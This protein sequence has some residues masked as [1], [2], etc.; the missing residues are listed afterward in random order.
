MKPT[1]PTSVLCA[2]LS[3]AKKPEDIFGTIFA[4]ELRDRLLAVKHQFNSF[5]V[6]IHPD[7]NPG[8]KDAGQHV[9]RLLA[10][11]T[12]AEK[13]LKEGS[14]GMPRKAVI[15]ATLRSPA[16]TY[17]VIE[18]YREGEVA[19]LFLSEHDGKRCLLKVVRQPTDNDL[20]DVEAKVLGER[21]R[22]DGGASA[23]TVRGRGA[24]ERSHSV[25]KNGKDFGFG[26]IRGA[27]LDELVEHAVHSGTLVRPDVPR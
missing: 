13:C 20:L 5:L 6:L 4:G 24:G 9:T 23:P 19:D 1:D 3:G 21:A 12:E 15:E 18:L 2:K 26:Y 8:L 22:P 27:T 10:L 25:I 16:G 7:Q 17:K 11:R 14:Y